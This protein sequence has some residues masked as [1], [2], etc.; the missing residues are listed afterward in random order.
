MRRRDWRYTTL[1]RAA[2]LAALLAAATPG[3]AGDD[4][5]KAVDTGLGFTISVPASWAKGTP[6]GNNKF[7]IGNREE[8]FAVIVT[9]FG[10]AQSDRAAAWALYQSSFTG[11]GFTLQSEA[12]VTVGGQPS[13]RMVFR[14]E[15]QSGLAHAE[16]VMLTVADEAYAILV[17]TPVAS[18]E[19]RRATIAAIIDS[20]KI[21]G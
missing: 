2:L 14:L 9:D 8:D 5:V 11:S 7:L 20:I 19:A 17:V 21:G 16:V 18:L 10:P 3:Y 13:K 12:E 4:A 15:T 1:L 6:S